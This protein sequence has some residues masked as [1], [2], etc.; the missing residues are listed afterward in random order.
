LDPTSLILRVAGEI[1]SLLES[2]LGRRNF[3]V[4]EGMVGVGNLLEGLLNRGTNT[5][6]QKN[7]CQAPPLSHPSDASPHRQQ[8]LQD[9]AIEMRDWR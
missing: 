3:R 6:Q 4:V 2:L 9:E 7:K 5:L 8:M 1:I